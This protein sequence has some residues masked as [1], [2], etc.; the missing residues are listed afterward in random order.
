LIITLVYEKNANFLPKIVENRK[1]LWSYNGPQVDQGCR[2]VSFRTQNPNLGKF[3]W[4]LK[5]T[6]LEYFMASWTILQTFWII[7]DLLVH[8]VFIW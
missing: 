2:M 4:P 6:I 1:K 5:W 8:F 3:W 7:Y